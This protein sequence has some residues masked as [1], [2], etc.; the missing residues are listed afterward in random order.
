MVSHFSAADFNSTS[1][2]RIS[3]GLLTRGA[4]PRLA[5]A[6]LLR[7]R[8]LLGDLNGSVDIPLSKIK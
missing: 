8:W 6:I 4:G 1:V 5:R 3:P 7:S 2:A